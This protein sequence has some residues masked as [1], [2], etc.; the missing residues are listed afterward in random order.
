MKNIFS[1]LLFILFP[2]ILFPQTN[3]T[4]LY[5]EDID[6]L[7]KALPGSSVEEHVD[8]LNEL[9]STYTSFNFDSSIYYSSRAEQL[10]KQSGYMSGLGMAKF[11]A[12]NAYYY[13]MDFKNALIE[14]LS[15]QSIFENGHY[16]NELGN[17]Y[18]ALGH[19]N[20]FITRTDKATYYY[21]KAMGYFQESGNAESVDNTNGLM[22]MTLFFIGGPPI[23]SA[24]FYANKTLEY[25]RKTGDPRRV[26]H[27]LMVV[28]MIYSMEDKSLLKKQKFL[29]YNDTAMKMVTTFH[30]EDRMCI[31]HLNTGG[32]FDEGYP[33]TWNPELSKSNYLEGLELAIKTNNK[34]MQSLSLNLLANWDIREGKYGQAASRLDSSEARLNEFFK[35]TAINAP[36][37]VFDPFNKIFTY[38]LAKREKTNLFQIRF[39]LAMAK[40]DYK[41][42]V[43]YQRLAFKSEEEFRAEQQGQQLD[44]VTAEDE[45]SR[46]KEKIQALAQDNEVARLNLSR[47]RLMFIGAGSG[48]I[49][50]S[51]FLL[52]YF[53]RKRLKAEQKSITLEQKLLRSQMNPHFIFNSL[54]SIQNFVV[55][56]KANEASIYLS[57]FSQLIRNILDNSTEEFVPLQKEIET[58]RH[59]L[60]LQQVRF[61]GQFTY[62]LEVD[63]KI[64]EESIMIPPML[65]QPF[66]ENAI[67]HG[68]RHKDTAGHIEIRFLLEN[69]LIRFEVEDDGIG[70]DKAR[71]IGLK[72]GRI[73]RSLSTSITHDRLARLNK[74]LKTKIRL[75][76][77][78]LKNSHGEACGTKVTFG[79]PVVER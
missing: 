36:G 25:A 68:I 7:V 18:L 42:A 13:K 77:T 70:R 69:K 1:F 24:L 65:A 52:L 55:N 47:T 54:A 50:I 8:I 26:A 46:Q 20:F 37:Y 71:E 38:F 23:D 56:H 28:G 79:I 2:C 27:A 60:D 32:Y 11:Q 53:Q 43:E 35:L 76:I 74:K 58:I 10:A 15:A 19:M 66:I 61:A 41:K 16:Y 3:P 59:Y 33:R 44:M 63:E 30:D 45:A 29:L 57:R 48:V 78:D 40:G 73:H 64:D 67:E 62:H 39:D 34:Y 14:Y 9:A 4:L 17:L 22:A 51:L 5:R 21:H 31:I 49:I 12:G 72:Q 6:S 75:E